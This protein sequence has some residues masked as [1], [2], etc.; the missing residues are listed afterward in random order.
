MYFGKNTEHWPEL[1]EQRAET[2][3]SLVLEKP[4][5]TKLEHYYLNL[6]Q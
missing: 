3:G 1:L 2:S 6:N 4:F 5:K